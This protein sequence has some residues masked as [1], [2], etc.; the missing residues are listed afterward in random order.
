MKSEKN[1][2]KVKCPVCYKEKKWQDNPYRP[3]CSERCSLIDLGKWSEGDYK[4][5]EN[6]LEEEPEVLN[7]Y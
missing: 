4:I 1:D 3:F 7:D 5:S 6:V 2:R